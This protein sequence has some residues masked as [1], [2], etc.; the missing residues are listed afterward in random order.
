MPK[1]FYGRLCRLIAILIVVGFSVPTQL[2]AQ[3]G[4]CLAAHP[5]ISNFKKNIVSAVTA[6]DSSV[7]TAFKLPAATASAVS[8]VTTDSICALAAQAF[9][10][11]IGVTGEAVGPVWVFQVGPTRYVVFDDR[12]AI[13]SRQQQVVFDA[14]FQYLVAIWG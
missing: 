2:R 13:D 7:R 4:S 3:A 9:H 10:A 12:H 1:Q 11:A 5:Y 14:N 8:L 6:T